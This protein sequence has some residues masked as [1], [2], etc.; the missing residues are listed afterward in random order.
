ML[1]NQLLNFIVIHKWFAIYLIFKVGDLTIPRVT[2]GQ[3][4]Q[5]PKRTRAEIYQ[6]FV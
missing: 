2:L 4:G 3:N 5:K 1:H 6:V